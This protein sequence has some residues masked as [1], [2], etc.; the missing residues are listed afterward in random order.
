GQQLVV[1]ARE[2][3]AKGRSQAGEQENGACGAGEGEGEERI[4]E[5][6]PPHG[7]LFYHEGGWRGFMKGRT[8]GLRRRRRG[9]G[10]NPAR[11]RIRDENGPARGP[12]P[13]RVGRREG[14]GTLR[15][16]A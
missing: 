8:P 9:A 10:V 3:E 2:L 11:G 1:V 6:A 7:R 15:V 14:T 5:R 4:R 12:A 13:E 16:I